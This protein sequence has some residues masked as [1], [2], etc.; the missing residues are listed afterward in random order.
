MISAP[1][2]RAILPGGAFAAAQEPPQDRKLTCGP[3]AEAILAEA[4]ELDVRRDQHVFQIVEGLGLGVPGSIDIGVEERGDVP[5]VRWTDHGLER[6]GDFE[7]F[8]IQ[9]LDRDPNG[10]FPGRSS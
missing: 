5:L 9:R 6:R 10:R 1:S 2:L 8:R 4:R 7:R 3:R